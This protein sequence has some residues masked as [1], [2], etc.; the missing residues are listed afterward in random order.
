MRFMLLVAIILAIP[1]APKAET[2]PPYGWEQCT[3]TFAGD[4]QR[5]LDFV[6]NPCIKS[7]QQCLMERVIAWAAFGVNMSLRNFSI[8][9]SDG[10]PSSFALIS[11]VL[12][13]AIGENARCADDDPQCMLQVLVPG[14]LEAF[15]PSEQ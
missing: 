9:Q 7:D 4:I 12:Q 13:Q 6:T 5:C 10:R 8:D 1:S 3:T 15:G 2:H 11:D 14:L